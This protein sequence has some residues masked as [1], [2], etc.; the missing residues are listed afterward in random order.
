MLTEEEKDTL[1]L[2]GVPGVGA[3]TFT[4]LTAIF[5]TP[6]GVF[7]AP[8]KELL[9]IDGVGPVLTEN[10]LKHNRN[11]YV[12]EQIKL[13]DKCGAVMLI[14]SGEKYPKLLKVFKSAP[15]VLFMRGNP[16]TFSE[17]SLAFVGTRRPTDYGI[18]MTK[19]LVSG[20]VRAG[21]VVVSGMAAGIDS[22]AHREAIAGGGKTVAVFGCGVDI[23]YPSFNRKLSGDIIK[24][25]CLVSHFQM[26]TLCKAG[27]FPARNAVIVGLSVGTIV[28]EAPSKSGALITAE[29]TLKAGRKLFTVPGN[30]DSPKSEGTN[31]LVSKG[32]F[33]VF[34][35]ENIL[36]ILGNNPVTNHELTKPENKRPLP[37]GLGGDILKILDEKPL[38]VETISENLGKTISEI[39]SELTFLEMDNF[40]RQKPGKYFEKI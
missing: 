20:A 26:G 35:I 10:I 19:N 27:N 34:S 31:N 2:F 33:P 24:N 13:M 16:D 21:M 28:V 14:K 6:A 37:E 40:V 12:S 7:G 9:S 17:S 39:L 8:K 3:K 11:E 18:K 30:A 29:L 23:I 15:P 5:G 36:Y 22:S 1:A 4:T 38:H 32:A 25:G